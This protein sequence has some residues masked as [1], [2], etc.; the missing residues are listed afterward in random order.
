MATRTVLLMIEDR[1]Y[2]DVLSEALVDAGHAV[3]QVDD[4]AAARAALAE[5][6]FDA[7]IVDLDTS[8][9]DGVQLIVRMRVEQPATTIIALLPCGGL[10]DGAP[11]PPYHLA[12]EKPARL[13]AILSAVNV[14]PAATRN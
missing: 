11:C 1:A 8:A 6:P 3:T 4:A 12:I 13:A 9:R 14:A 7:G 10:P 5:H 2:S